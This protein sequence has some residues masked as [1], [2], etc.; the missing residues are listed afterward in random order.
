MI[1]RTRQAFAALWALW[2]ATLV[3]AGPMVHECPAHDAVAPGA[4]SASTDHAAHGSGSHQEPAEDDCDHCS[5][6]GDCAGAALA[7]AIAGAAHA[8]VRSLSSRALVAA[9]ALAPSTGSP[10]VRL[11]FS[12][13]P[14]LLA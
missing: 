13:G 14:P 12:V 9:G 11:P 4:A 6:L 1:R 2:F 7:P 10:H 5:C 8:S 3:V